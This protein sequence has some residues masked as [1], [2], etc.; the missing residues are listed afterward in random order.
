M[1]SHLILWLGLLLGLKWSVADAA[2]VIPAGYR[3][4]ATEQGV[5]PAVLYAIALAE[6]GTVLSDDRGHKPWPWTLNIQGEGRYFKSRGE[7]VNALSQALTMGKTSVDIGLM[8]VNWRYHQSSLGAVERAIDP[9]HNLRVGAHIL[10]ACFQSRGDWWAAVG[11]YHA[12]NNQAHATRYR[13]RVYQ[14]WQRLTNAGD[15]R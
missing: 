7:A 2:E 12:P 5:P 1:G 3:S 10:R 11:C 6:S 8:Q 14:L 13:K 15:L 9:Y 4:V